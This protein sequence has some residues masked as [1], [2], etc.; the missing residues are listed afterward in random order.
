MQRLVISPAGPLSGE[1]RIEGAKN[2]VLKL[3]AAALLAEG[4][5]ELVNVPDITD[6]D[7]MAELLAGMGV[8]WHHPDGD[9]SRVVLDVP[10]ELRPEAPYELAEKIRASTAV[11][12]PLLGRC[13]RVVVALPGGDNF[14]SRPIDMHMLGLEAMGAQFEL[15]HGDVVAAAPDGLVGAEITLDF[16]SVGATENIVMAAVVAKGTTVLDNAAREPE[17]VDLCQFLIGMGAVIDGIGSPVVTV[18]G[19]PRRDLHPVNHRVVGDRIEAATYL[20]AVGVAGGEIVIHE[21]KAAHMENL[22]RKLTEMGV[23]VTD[24]GSGLWV[25]A[26][27]RL[28]SIDVATLPYP[29][30]ATDAKPILTAMLCVGDGVGIV[31][32]NLF[33][34]RFRYVTELVRLGADIRT[35]AHHAVIRGVPRLSGAPVRAHDIRAGASLVVAALAADGDTV[36]ADAHHLERGYPNLVAKLRAIGV[37]AR[38]LD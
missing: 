20:A 14:G 18:H 25:R 1:I 2:S 37:D 34:G 28:R 11:I 24:T 10:S 26:T 32:E 31:T 16:P 7:V 21:A 27:E 6:V 8:R 5:Y 33:A 15:R 3:M 12:G 22:V 4:T 19:V 30:V 9:Q 13:G 36:I 35:D 17:I 38:V 23:S 29:G